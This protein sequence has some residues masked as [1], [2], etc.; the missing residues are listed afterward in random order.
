[1]KDA[2]ELAKVLHRDLGVGNIV[3]YKGKGYLIDWDLAKLVN[4]HGPRQTTR[5][6]TW[7]FM[8]VYLVEHKYA[9][10]LVKDDLESSFYI[11]LWT[12]LKYKE[13]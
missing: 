8:S 11:V 6:G 7:Q 10:Y 3:I 12:T 9:I 2:F 4:I 5:T 1:H 13:T